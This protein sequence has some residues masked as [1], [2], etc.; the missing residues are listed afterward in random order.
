MVSK[1]TYFFLGL[2]LCSSLHAQKG[3]SLFDPT[4]VHEIRLYF[5][6]DQFFENMDSLWD[7]HHE[8][9]GINVPYTKALIQIDG[10]WLDTTG[11]R[12]KG[13]SSYYKANS[14]KK[15]FKV[16]F[17]EFIDGQEY[18]GIKKFNL[19]NGAC[20]PGML[21]DFLA[22]DVLRKAGVPAPRVSHC[23]LYFN[24]EFWGVYSIIEQIDKTFLKNNFANDKGT[25]IKNTGWDELKWK[26]PD[27]AP[28]LE[29]YEMKTNEVEG[30]WTDFLNF[31]NVFTHISDAEFP[32]SIHQVF[33]VDLFLHVMAVDVMTNNWDSYIDG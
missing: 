23:R 9:S 22:Y 11:I 6:E 3:N 28:Y 29:D 20:D 2:L 13:L 8:A 25:L 19:H 30:D 4:Y 24:D 16:D 18:D 14:K 12:I 15:P 32:A 7:V 27:I 26:G 21:R 31:V 5:F 17:N 10:N 1:L 33:D